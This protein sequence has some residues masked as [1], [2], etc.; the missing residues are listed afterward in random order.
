MVGCHLGVGTGRGAEVVGVIDGRPADGVLEEGDL[1]LAFDGA[2]VATASDLVAAVQEATP[3]T[4]VE[5]EVERSR[6][7]QVVSV[8]LNPASVN[9]DG[10]PLLGVNVVTEVDFLMPDELDADR[11]DTQFSRAIELEGGLFS[12]DPLGGDW[13]SFEA[14]SGGRG[15][16]AFGDDFWALSAGGDAIEGLVSGEE[17][18]VNREEWVLQI[19]FAHLSGQ[20]QSGGSMLVLADRSN[21]EV[22]LEAGLLALSTESLDVQWSWVPGLLVTEA[23]QASQWV[24]VNAFP[25]PDGSRL[26]VAVATTESPTLGAAVLDSDGQ[27]ATLW[28]AQDGGPFAGLLGLGWY[29][30]DT[31]TFFDPSSGATLL[32]PVVGGLS[33]IADTLPDGV[34]SLWPV[35][36]G[37]HM[38]IQAGDGLSLVNAAGDTR[39]LSTLCGVPTVSGV[40]FR[41]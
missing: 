39:P 12:L 32:V 8:E 7:R 5:L 37:E 18:T 20:D 28:N 24:P 33:L 41:P 21:D 6:S 25:S 3:G 11:P 19:P 30:D 31:L 16:V 9:T 17:R 36:D 40:G 23:G 14:D 22:A 2:P 4:E 13:Y 35:G 34:D 10:S 29:D 26:L 38:I 27:L 1:V 15:W